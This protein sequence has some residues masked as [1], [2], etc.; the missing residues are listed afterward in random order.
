MVIAIGG[1]VFWELSGRDVMLM[2]EVLVA[3]E[4][5]PRGSKIVENNLVVWKVLKG[6]KVSGGISPEQLSQIK[7]KELKLSII[8]NQQ[9]STKF[10]EKEG[11][12]LK[13]NQ[14]YF[15]IKEPWIEMRSSVLRRG[16]LVEIYG[17]DPQV[18]QEENSVGESL[19]QGEQP[20][21]EP[22]SRGL[23]S[24]GSYK[25]AF[26]KD[27]TERE[28]YTA[29][30]MGVTKVNGEERLD[31]TSVIQHIEIICTL[32]EYLQIKKVGEA[33]EVPSLTIVQRGEK[34]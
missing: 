22:E 29:D 23:K 17:M 34:S 2:E 14:S 15:V 1:L 6:H 30:E 5:L 13:E 31:S 28:V 4:D 20:Y 19:G 7:D 18:L 3:K 27:S 25:I 26:V 9:I 32:E 12:E 33:W 10:F 11:M 8:K 16:D 21:G 24:L